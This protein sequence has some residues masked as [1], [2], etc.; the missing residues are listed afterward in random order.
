MLGM[1]ALEVRDPVTGFVEMKSRNAAR[2]S[3]QCRPFYQE[4]VVIG[5]SCGE[6]AVQRDHGSVSAPVDSRL[7]TLGVRSL[8]AAAARS[9]G[10]HGKSS[11]FASALG[12]I[13]RLHE[14]DRQR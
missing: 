14:C 4:L 11:L 7:S 10:V 6:S 8:Q 3:G 12:K 5:S 13:N 2:G 9:Q 1:T